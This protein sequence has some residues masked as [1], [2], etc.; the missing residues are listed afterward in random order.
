[1]DPEG[2]KPEEE[3]PFCRI[4]QSS[5][6]PLYVVET[7]SPE[8]LAS[9]LF[10]LH[11]SCHPFASY[12]R[13]FDFLILNKKALRDFASRT[14]RGC[15]VLFEWLWFNFWREEVALCRDPT[16]CKR[17]LVAVRVI[18]QRCDGE[19]GGESDGSFCASR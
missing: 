13:R 6:D 18:R 12:M 1:M 3:S 17:H 10:T 16:L 2:Q 15:G 19:R 11:T 9:S 4:V 14:L 5:P 8:L 7:L